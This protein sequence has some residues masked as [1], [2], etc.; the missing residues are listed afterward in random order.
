MGLGYLQKQ[1]ANCS[2]HKPAES[3]AQGSLLREGLQLTHRRLATSAHLPLPTVAGSA[4]GPTSPASLG[5]RGRASEGLSLSALSS[6][7]WRKGPRAPYVCAYEGRGQRCGGWSQAS[8]ATPENRASQRVPE[9]D[10]P[11]WARS[12]LR[13]RSCPGQGALLRDEFSW[14]DF[15][16]LCPFSEVLSLLS[17]LP[18]KSGQ[19][20]GN[21]LVAPGLG[22]ATND[23]SVSHQDAGTFLLFGHMLHNAI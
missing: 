2:T 20:L 17:W 5:H 4:S 1:R 7:S 12:D 10:P 6:P 13:D 16:A 9:R 19:A 8:Q 23:L 21:L 22:S 15:P 14:A 18:D 3:A 11:L